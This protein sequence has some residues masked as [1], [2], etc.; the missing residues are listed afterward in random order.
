MADEEQVRFWWFDRPSTELTREELL[1]VIDH[2]NRELESARAQHGR[3]LDFLC[4]VAT[5]AR[6]GQ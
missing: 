3:D 1:D 5:S 4:A 6:G 2:M